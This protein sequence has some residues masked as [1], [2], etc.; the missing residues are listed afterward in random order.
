MPI[1]YIPEFTTQFCTGI[2]QKMKI[3]QDTKNLRNVCTKICQTNGGHIWCGDE[4]PNLKC[5]DGPATDVQLAG[6]TYRGLVT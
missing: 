2:Y 6:S 1:V 4:A 5:L 3:C